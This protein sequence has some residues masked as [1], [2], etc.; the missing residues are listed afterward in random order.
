MTQ[1]SP[2][3][4][5]HDKSETI[6]SAVMVKLSFPLSFLNNADRLRELGA[7]SSSERYNRGDRVW[8]HVLLISGRESFCGYK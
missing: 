8:L 4:V 5:L 6:S 1:R 2:F 3:Q 7:R